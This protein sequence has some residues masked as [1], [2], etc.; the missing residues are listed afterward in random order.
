MNTLS[1]TLPN[2]NFDLTI[3]DTNYDVM[4]SINSDACFTDTVDASQLKEADDMPTLVAAKINKLNSLKKKCTRILLEYLLD[5]KFKNKWDF[6]SFL[7]HLEF[8]FINDDHYQVYLKT[9]LPPK[10]SKGFGKASDKVKYIKTLLYTDKEN[11]ID[12]IPL[13]ETGLISLTLDWEPKFT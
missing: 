11:K 12:S 3:P 10:S 6:D 4:G 7:T 8:K 1:P 9:K 2:F 5:Y 13:G